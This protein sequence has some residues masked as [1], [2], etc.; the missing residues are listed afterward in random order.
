VADDDAAILEVTGAILQAAG[1]QVLL[2]E[3][4]RQAVRTYDSVNKRVHLLLTDVVMPDLNGPVLAA[5][6]RARD[7][8]LKVLFIS[9]FHD[10]QFVQ[11]SVGDGFAL[12]AKPFSREA[13]LRAVR[14]CLTPVG[15]GHVARIT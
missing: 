2:A 14:D 3:G 12:L 11:R 4:G 8:G 1:Y 7:P 9:G 5:R 15:R 13:L 6:L 10:A